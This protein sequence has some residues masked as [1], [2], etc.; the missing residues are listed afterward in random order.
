MPMTALEKQALAKFAVQSDE[1]HGMLEFRTL[2]ETVPALIFASNADGGHVYTNSAYQRYSGLSFNELLGHGFMK[3]VHEDDVAGMPERWAAIL[4]KG[5]PFEAQYRL[6]R[7]DGAYRWHVV[8]G[9]PVKDAHGKVLR[10]TGA[11]TDIEDMR[12]A[13]EQ[14]RDNTEMLQSMGKL[15]DALV[16][17]K[18]D[19]GRMLAANDATLAVLGRR[20]EQVIGH[21]IDLMGGS[22]EEVAIINAADAKVLETGE[23]HISEEPWTGA[24]GV[25]RVFRSAKGPWRRAD[26]TVGIVAV[27]VDVSQERE[28]QQRLERSEARFQALVAGLP[29]LLWMTDSQGRMIVQNG[30]WC[31]YLG[32]PAADEEPVRFEDIVDPA[33]FP[34]FAEQWRTC[35]A[36]G[37]LLE[38]EV[39]LFD[40]LEGKYMPH[41]MTIV[42]HYAKDGAVEGWVGSATP[43]VSA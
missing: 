17:A 26:G 32:F 4:A 43:L 40:R 14:A 38:T 30:L 1:W 42:P 37:E 11:C 35:V 10:W 23:V 19:Q 21:R 13:V 24:D 12:S 20:S 5:E 2:A 18:D 22:D 28:L 33:A 27:T 16:F 6:R 25:T 41:K 29:L 3:L 7:H 15:T 31:D 39:G 36:T 9:G 34:L 8:R